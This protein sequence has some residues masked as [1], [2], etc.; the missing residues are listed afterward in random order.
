MLLNYGIGVSDLF[1][2]AHI[3]CGQR[4]SSAAGTC[5]SGPRGPCSVAV[6]SPS[7]SRVS[8]ELQGTINQ[9][10]SRHPLMVL[11]YT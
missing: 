3:V 2:N 7:L 5:P 10:Y 6:L 9:V 11:I 1:I 8:R 4:V